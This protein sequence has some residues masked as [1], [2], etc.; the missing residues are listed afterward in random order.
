VKALERDTLNPTLIIGTGATAYCIDA[1]T[2]RASAL[3]PVAM[4]AYAQQLLA[5]APAQAQDDAPEAARLYSCIAMYLGLV[6][7][8]EDAERLIVHA[9]ALQADGAPVPLLI[10]QIRR[11]QIVQML[12]RPAEASQLLS[13]AVEQCRAHPEL[14]ILLDFALQHLGKVQFDLGRHEQALAT[15]EEALALRESK[16]DAELIASTRLAIQAV[17]QQV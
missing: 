7:D 9:I 10:S 1:K 17:K 13:I 5:K 14:N 6:G 15:F 11:A 12:G 8:L 2:L 4:R 3:D 16:A